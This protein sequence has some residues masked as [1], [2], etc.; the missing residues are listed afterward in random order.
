MRINKPAPAAEPRVPRIVLSVRVDDGS[1]ESQMSVAVDAS[2]EKKREVALNWFETMLFGL[3]Q[4][5]DVSINIEEF[6]T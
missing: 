1:F 3:Q 6:R 5:G 2:E 4:K